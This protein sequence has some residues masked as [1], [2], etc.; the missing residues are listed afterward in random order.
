MTD[1][2]IVAPPKLKFWDTAL[3]TLISS[4]GIRWI[5]VAAAEQSHPRT[6]YVVPAPQQ[7]RRRAIQAEI[8]SQHCH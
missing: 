7:R 5:A 4:T 6:S 2:T 1:A 8:I 3:Y